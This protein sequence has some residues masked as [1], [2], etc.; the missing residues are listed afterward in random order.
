MIF[1][2]MPTMVVALIPI[3]AI[4]SAVARAFTAVSFSRIVRGVA[5]ANAVSTL[6]GIPI[7][8]GA[9]LILN[10]V[11][12]G[13]TTHGFDTPWN[14]FKTVVLQASW[15]VPYEDQ[16]HWLVPAATMVL[17]IPYY[18]A[19]VVSERL[20]LR[21]IF[22]DQSPQ[23]ISKAAWSMNGVSYA[24]LVVLTAIWLWQEVAL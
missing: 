13:G 22:K 4:E 12:T 17:L 16:L 15:L 5:V 18:L 11:A 20:V 19:S 2:Q 24:I 10:I 14:A 21:R 8:W 9:M 23:I 7:A 6:I 1:W 3:I